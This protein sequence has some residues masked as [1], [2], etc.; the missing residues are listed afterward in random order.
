MLKWCQPSGGAVGFGDHMGFP[1]GSQKGEH[2]QALA[3][4]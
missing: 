1:P 4:P 2:L 3:D